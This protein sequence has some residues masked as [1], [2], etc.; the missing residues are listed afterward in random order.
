MVKLSSQTSLMQ[1][2]VTKQLLQAPKAS[3][4]WKHNSEARV[5][6]EDPGFQV[7]INKIFH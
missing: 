5:T 7:E 1:N 4:S 6:S 3:T 2:A